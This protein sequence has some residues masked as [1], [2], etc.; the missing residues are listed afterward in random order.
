MLHRQKTKG[1]SLIEYITL[2][3]LILGAFL[4][5]QKYIARGFAGR[6]KSVGESMGQGRIYDPR[7]TT[8][9]IFDS[10]YTNLWYDK[11]CFDSRGCD[12]LSVRANV[13]TC[14]DC[15]DPACTTSLPYC[16]G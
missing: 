4:V 8:E 11:A 14:Q 16:N 13:D 3:V 6:W 10:L 1:Q 5:F 9:C 15:F 7:M 2:I 12:C